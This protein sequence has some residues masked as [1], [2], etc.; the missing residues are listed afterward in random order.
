MRSIQQRHLYLTLVSVL[1]TSSLPA[2]GVQI[3]LAGSSHCSGRVELFYGNTWGTVCDDD[4]DIRDAKVVCRQ[5]TCGTALSAPGGASFGEGT[6]P[7]LLDD[8]DCSGSEHSL[9]ECQSR[10]ITKHNCK[11]NE[12]AGVVCSG[13]QIRLAGSTKC[14]GRVE[15]FYGSTWGTVCDDDW[16]LKDAEVVCRQLSCGTAVSA[17]GGAL[18]GEGTGPILLDNV[19]CSGSESFLTKCQSTKMKTHNC[20]HNEDAGVICSVSLPKPRISMI[21]VGEVTW[22]QD[23]VIVC[24]ITAELRGGT[25]TLQKIPGSFTMTQ[26]PSSNS[27][28]FNILQV[29]LE[30]EGSYQCQYRKSISSQNFNSVLSDPLR[31]FISVRLQ[32]PSISLTS[33]DRGLV[34]SPEGAEVTMGYRFIFTCSINCS[35]PEGQFFLISSDSNTIATKRTVNHSASFDFP[36]ADYKHQGNYSCVYEVELPTRRFNSTETGPISVIIKLPLLR[37]VS[38]VAAGFLLLLLLLVLLVVVCLACGRRKQAKQPNLVHDKLA[39]RV[40]KYCKDDKMIM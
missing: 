6:G 4:W 14:S 18:F 33:P 23:I 24:S 8:V 19:A 11:H 36:V 9:T 2:A 5:L 20:Q 29:D 32:Q 30:N 12:D 28:T 16:D 31:L 26:T 1:W 39:V 22:G 40:G 27:A 38:S 17:P 13:A 37:M 10:E 15:L 7:I 34:W 21:P 35:Y 3:R 25:F